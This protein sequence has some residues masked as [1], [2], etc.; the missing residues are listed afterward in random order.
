MKTATEAFELQRAE[1][2]PTLW[3]IAYIV[4]R[5]GWCVVDP[6]GNPHA[7]PYSAH[8]D[9]VEAAQTMGWRMAQ[10]WKP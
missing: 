1:R 6:K 3:I 10:G 4:E 9:A 8:A 7:G 5:G 2:V